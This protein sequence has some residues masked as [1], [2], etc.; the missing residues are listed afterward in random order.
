MTKDGLSTINYEPSMTMD[1]AFMTKAQ[2]FL[3]KN[4]LS[5]IKK[6][7]SLTKKM[8]PMTKE[9]ISVVKERPAMI[10]ETSSLVMEIGSSFV[11]ARRQTAANLS[12]SFPDGG[13]LPRRRYAHAA[14]GDADPVL[15]FKRRQV[16]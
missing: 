7:I 9:I 10:K 13:A 14:E 8:V 16:M 12:F 2:P 1:G 4:G 11:V 15:K 6:I 3:I 5:M